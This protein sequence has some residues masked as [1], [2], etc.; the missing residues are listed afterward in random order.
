MIKSVIQVITLA[1]TLS[2]KSGKRFCVTADVPR[3][4]WGRHHTILAIIVAM[5][6]P[7]PKTDLFHC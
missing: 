5:A 6:Q 2:S 3:V 4:N 7:H 1:P